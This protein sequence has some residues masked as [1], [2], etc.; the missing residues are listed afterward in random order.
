MRVARGGRVFRVLRW[1]FLHWHARDPRYPTAYR[2]GDIEIRVSRWHFVRVALI[3]TR[4]RWSWE[5]IRYPGHCLHVYCGPLG[6][7]FIDGRPTGDTRW[8]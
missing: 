4:A 3:R 6:L 8:K 7:S 2:G 1:D 5:V